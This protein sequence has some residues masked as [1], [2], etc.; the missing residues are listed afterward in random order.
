MVSIVLDYLGAGESAEAIMEQYPT[1]TREDIRAAI[2]Y[3]AWLAHQE[4]EQP[5]YTGTAR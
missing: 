5:L 2:A 3:A 4:E 1:L